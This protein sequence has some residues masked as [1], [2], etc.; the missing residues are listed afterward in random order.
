MIHM[1]MSLILNPEKSNVGTVETFGTSHFC[2]FPG[3][4]LVNPFP[5]FAYLELFSRLRLRFEISGAH[6]I[7]MTPIS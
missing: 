7:M 3:T 1:G 6:C 2:D 5:Y 4:K